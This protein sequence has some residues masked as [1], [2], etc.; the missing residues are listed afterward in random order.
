MEVAVVALLSSLFLAFG[1]KVG[2]FWRGVLAFAPKWSFHRRNGRRNGRRK[3]GLRHAL[4]EGIL[5]VDVQLRQPPHGL[6]AD[7]RGG[8]GERRSKLCVS[9]NRCLC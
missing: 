7:R 2:A 5:D 1:P 6:L 4:G 3:P 9:P 8:D